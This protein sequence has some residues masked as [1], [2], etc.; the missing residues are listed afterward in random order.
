VF[1]TITGLPVHILVVHAVVVLGPLCA[2]GTVVAAVSR[3][4]FER[5][6]T[7][8][9]VVLTVALLSAVV[10]RQSGFALRDAR[11]LGGDQL[12]KHAHLG[13]WVP[14]AMLAYWA[15]VVG[16]VWA[17]RKRGREDGLTKVLLVLSVVAAVG[18]TVLIVLTGDA[19]SRALWG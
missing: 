19:G 10:A 14:L 8:L 12:A 1:D 6:S 5:L 9:V 7:A 17:D 2:V 16:W 11:N 15:M 13:T 3:P 18:S 4:W